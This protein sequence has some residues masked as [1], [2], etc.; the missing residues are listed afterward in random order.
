M[1]FWQVFEAYRP[2]PPQKVFGH[3][4][5]NWRVDRQDAEDGLKLHIDGTYPDYA[6]IYINVAGTLICE[7]SNSYQISARTTVELEDKLRGL[8][9]TRYCGYDDTH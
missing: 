4:V 3:S 2:S 9:I 5:P 1:R 7:V 6:L 8:G